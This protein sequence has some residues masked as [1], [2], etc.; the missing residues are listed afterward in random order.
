MADSGKALGPV[1]VWALAAGG[2]VGGGIYIALGVVIAAAGIWSWLSFLLAG[3]V[4]VA[5]AWS[6]ATLSNHFGKAGGAFEFLEE[7]NR[8]GWA[9]SLS[10]LLIVGYTL[11]ISVYAYAFGHYVAWSF[12]GGPWAIRL[13]AAGI[14]A[15]LIGLNLLG[16]GKMTMVEV[17]I[18]SGNL[19]ALLV[20]AAFG[21]AHWNP[22]QL[23][24]GIAAH[25]P[26]AAFAGAAAIFMSYEGFQLLA[27]DY[28]EVRDAQ[29]LFVPVLV[30]AAIFVVFVYV[31]VA[32]GAPML[33]GAGAIVDQR[34]VALSVAAR[35]AAGT[36]GMIAMTV[37]AGFATSAAINSTL[38]ST[39]K[40][41]RRVADDGELPRWIDHE[42]GAG[43]PDRPVVVIGVLAGTLAVI[44]SLSSLVEAASLVFLVTFAIVN[45]MAWRHAG[46]RKWI[47]GIGMALG[48][49]IGTVLIIRLARSE[50]IPLAV[51][52]I[53]ML[54]AIF[55]R[56]RLLAGRGK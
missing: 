12:G 15:A 46:R 28:D 32:L 54:V 42:N 25:P 3:I 22:G 18:V 16:V 36:P 21:L 39:A 13:L 26:T 47:P 20:L 10:W 30:S 23:S 34:E 55:V 44:G 24:N 50:T 43:V 45:L 19:I 33:V 48:S 29:R 49:V 52:G 37:A 4:A 14:A 9:G 27:Y 56:P 51:L 1:R 17:V 6:Y 53:L 2:M 38:F 11:T 31:V 8:E 40:L 41:A 35:A 5:T 7:S